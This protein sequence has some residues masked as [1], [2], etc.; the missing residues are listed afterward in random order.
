MQ[1]N[2]QQNLIL[3]R[4]R[5]LLV[6]TLYIT[7]LLLSYNFLRQ[8]W[9]SGREAQWLVV[10]ATTMMLFLGIFWW[11]LHHNHRPTEATLLPFLGY[12]NSMTLARGL[13]TALL[14]GFLFAPRPTGALAW[15]PAI[16]Y[17]LERLL[18]YFDGYVARITGQETK[19]GAILDMEFDSLGF[20]IA[21]LLCIQ[22]GQ[23]P[24]WYLVLGLARQLFVAGMWLRQRAKKQLAALPASE[25]RRMIAGF[26]TSFISVVLWPILS[27]QITLFAGYLF[28]LPLIYSFGR[29]WLVVSQILVEESSLYRTLRQGVKKFFEGWLPLVARVTGTWFALHILWRAIP[30]FAAWMMYYTNSSSHIPLPPFW[31]L[32]LLWTVASVLFFTGVLG[33]VAA[34]ALF[35]LASLDI[36]ATNLHWADNGLLFICAIIVLHLGSGKFALWQP[37]ERWVHMKLGT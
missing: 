18:D 36:V 37:E 35:C 4:W 12:G 6:A 24:V 27:P 11:A 13:C 33:R 26:Q 7:G 22:Y 34:L 15:V 31:G 25:Q 28:A 20:L 9:Q 3:L 16:L 8:Q 10:A 14:A 2:N 19:L 32:A 29:D 1:V 21:I 23:L 30:L 5:W 17:T